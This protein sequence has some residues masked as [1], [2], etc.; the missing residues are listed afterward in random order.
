MTADLEEFLE[1]APALRKL[2]NAERK[3]SEARDENKGLRALVKEREEELTRAHRE[4]DLF[5]REWT[6]DPK[7]LRPKRKAEQHGG[8]LV[9]MLS[10][11]H[12]GEVVDAR[13]MGGY[14]AYNLEIAERRTK[15]Y[16]EKLL[17]LPNEYLAGV[18]YEGIVLALGGDLISG[19]IHDELVETNEL[20][21][22]ETVEVV[23]PWLKAGIEKLYEVYGNVHVVSVPGNHGRPT[24]KPKHKGYSPSNADSHIAR[25][26][27]TFTEGATF[28]V[29][30][31]TD[32]SFQVQGRE[33]SM[34]H[35]H[36]AKGGDGQVGA[37]GPVKRLVLRKKQQMQ[38]E[39]QPFKYLLVGHFH[40]FVAAQGQGFVM[41]G[42]L[43]GYDEFARSFHFVPEPPQ[44]ALM[45]VTP[46]HGITVTMPILV[47][48][49]KTEGW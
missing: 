8:T 6:A 28:N 45:L 48:D 40:Q 26:L 18:S 27:A 49:R 35:G 10:D 44:Q 3:L 24:R 4:L 43:K 16:F 1:E 32:V 34:E 41:N 20:S 25:L 33:F 39:G 31:S 38:E 30:R 22:L 46:E 13:E 9:A 2:L 11:T 15:R 17:T 29:P 12:Y 36:S 47:G 21:T 5:D 7:W 23:L 37:L 19:D 14:N 42:S